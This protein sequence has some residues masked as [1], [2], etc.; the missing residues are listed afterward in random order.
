MFC[1][2]SRREPFAAIARVTV[3]GESPVF[4]VNVIVTV[5]GEEAIFVTPITVVQFPPPP[6]PLT[7][8]G[9]LA[10][11]TADATLIPLVTPHSLT[12]NPLTTAVP[13]KPVA[14]VTRM[15]RAF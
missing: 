7:T 2:V 1:A 14:P 13:A 5:W 4:G 10:S 6:T 3:T 9:K 12:R 15:Y 8:C 11:A